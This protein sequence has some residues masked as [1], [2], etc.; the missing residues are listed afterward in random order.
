MSQPLIL[1]VVQLFLLVMA[2]SVVTVGPN[3]FPDENHIFR[4][5]KSTCGTETR[6]GSF[7]GLMVHSTVLG[8]FDH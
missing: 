6:D 2:G 5:I 4:L 1:Y 8:F 7:K 3:A